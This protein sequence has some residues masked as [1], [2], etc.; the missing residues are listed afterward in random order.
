MLKASSLSLGPF[1]GFVSCTPAGIPGCSSCDSGRALSSQCCWL[2]SPSASPGFAS[3]QI[4]AN[5]CCWSPSALSR[6][7]SWGGHKMARGQLSLWCGVHLVHE[8]KYPVM[9]PLSLGWMWMWWVQP[10]W[11]EGKVGL[12]TT[13]FFLKN[14]KKGNTPFC[15]LVH[16]LHLS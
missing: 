5:S 2:I 7:S 9:E 1:C 15:K 4:P 16:S 13:Q 8:K 10:L 12:S 3:G 6:R 14:R 11:R